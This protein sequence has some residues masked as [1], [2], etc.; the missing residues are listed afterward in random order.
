M[1]NFPIGI[2]SDC[3]RLPLRQGIQ[4][5]AELGAQ[6]V[7]IY[8]VAGDMAPENLN[9]AQRADLLRFIKD[10]GL[11]VS[12]LC[13]DLGGHGFAVAEDNAL[14][15][16]RSK[17]ILDLALDMECPVVTTHIGVLPA[18]GPDHPRWKVMADACAP[19]AE[20]G[21]QVGAR[22]AVETGPE[23]AARL[24]LF[25]DGL[26]S[27]GVG[28][29]MDPANLVMVV[30]DDPAQAVRTLGSYIVHTHAKDGVMVKQGDPEA[31]Y[32]G[33]AGMG[34]VSYDD[35]F[36][37][38]P[39]GKGQVN[40]QQYLQALRDIGYTGFLT[41]EREVGADPAKDIAEAVAFLKAL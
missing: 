29:N 4:R 30:A 12:A 7:Q 37:E 2:I 6:G 3:F 38:V 32:A 9:P 21:D 10:Q 20:Y 11:R 19:L 8:A 33:F 31:I 5:A 39:L 1:A 16:E 24:K 14:R 22:F 27:K 23:P 15:V 25:L 13:G 41:I 35:F 36:R 40:W 34:D 26:G 17:R 28:V 18:Q